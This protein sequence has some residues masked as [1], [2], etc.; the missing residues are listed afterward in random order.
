MFY[1][2]G[3]WFF[4]FLT[5]YKLFFSFNPKRKLKI[6]IL[7]KQLHTILNYILYFMH[8]CCEHLGLFR[9]LVQDY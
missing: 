7:T 9:Y 2:L 3:N 8:N 1:S 6:Q 4:F 5:N